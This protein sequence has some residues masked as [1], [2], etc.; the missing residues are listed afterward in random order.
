VL[1]RCP[2]YVA[3][4]LQVNW[5]SAFTTWAGDGRAPGQLDQLAA[6]ITRYRTLILDPVQHGLS[7]GSDRRAHQ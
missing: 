3:A 5:Q 2:R 7:V 6:I 1:A 4:L